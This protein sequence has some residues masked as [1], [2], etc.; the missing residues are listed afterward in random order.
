MRDYYEILGVERTATA[1][2]IKRAYRKLALKYHPDRNPDDPTAEERFKEAAEA[3]EVLSNPEKRQRYD[4][5]GHAGVRGN[6]N[7]GPGFQDIN[8]I[9]SAFSDIFGGGSI[10]EEVFGGGRARG[11]GPRPRGRPGSDLRIKLPLTYEEIAEGVEKKIKVRKYVVCE[12]CAGTGAEGREQGYVVC[13]TCGGTGEIR[14]VT[15][16]V[17]GQ[18]VNVQPCPACQG[19]GRVVRHRCAACGGEGRRKGEETITINVPPGVL[20][21]HYLTLRGAGNAGVRGGPAGD[22]RVEIEELPHEHFTREGL[23]IYYELYLSFPDAV[24]GT[25]VEVPTLKGRA[26]LQID[27]GV[28]SG[29][30]LRMRERGLPELHGGRVGDQM[31]RIHVWTPTS[32]TDEERQLLE[33]L[34]HSPS[35]APQPE[36][37]ERRSFFSKFKDVFT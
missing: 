3:Y 35:F 19:E 4:R 32:L 2:E 14:H 26:R 36:R 5:F 8:D 33:Q 6:G 21:G 7:A 16:S 27:P 22:L 30:I 18:F 28:Q 15:R 25:E 13:P 37:Q 17:F 12:A 29:K 34:R 20:E 9:F 1:E 23:D 24:L 10:F 31:V 11:R